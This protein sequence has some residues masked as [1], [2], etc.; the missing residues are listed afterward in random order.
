MKLTILAFF[1]RL[2][3]YDESAI[4]SLCHEETGLMKNWLRNYKKRLEKE[5]LPVHK[6][7]LKMQAINPKYVLKNYMLQEAIELAEAGDFSLVNQLLEIARNP[8]EEHRGFEKYKK[9]TQKEQCDLML[10]CS[11]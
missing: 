1:E 2:S 5:I 11:S 10:S 4:L 9:P 7:F 6:H 3:Y 8:F